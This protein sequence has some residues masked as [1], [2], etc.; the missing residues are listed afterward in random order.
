MSP[1]DQELVDAIWEDEAIDNKT[2]E[3]I[4]AMAELALTRVAEGKIFVIPETDTF[5]FLDVTLDDIIEII[6]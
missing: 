3:G 4:F 2:I 5:E 1:Q 6:K